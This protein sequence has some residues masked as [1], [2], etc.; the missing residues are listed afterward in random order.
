M[1]INVIYNEDCIVGMQ[2]IPSDCID[3]IVTS[4]PYNIGIEYDSYNDKLD[5][6]EYY[7]WCG[8][9]MKEIHRILKPDGKLC[10]NHYLSF[11]KAERRLSPIMDLNTQAKDIGFK[12]HAIVLWMDEHRIKYTA[13]GSW[14]SASAPY[15]NCPVEGILI[16]YKNRW[17]KDKKGISTISKEEFIEACSGVWRI[18][19]EMKEYTKANFP[20]ELPKRCI[21]LLTYKNDIVLDPFMGAGTTAIAAIETGRN[22]IGFEISSNY[23]KIAKRRINNIISQTKLEVQ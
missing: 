6:D 2:S 22:Y 14:L 10:L 1:E 12:H 15:I 19:P 5:W 9:W 16:L 18:R 20:V 8:D 7:N 3:L 11:G 4:P 21:N 13:W 23:C 17:K